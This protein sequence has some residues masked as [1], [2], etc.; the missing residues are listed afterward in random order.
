VPR[1][2]D[3]P[4][5]EGASDIA[6]NGGPQFQFTEAISLLVHCDDQKEVDE[7]WSKLSAGGQEQ[8]CGWLKDKIGLSW[9]II[10]TA[11]LR[12]LQDRDAEKS[13]RVMEAMLPMK[14]IEIARL[15]E[16]YGRE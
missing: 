1:R 16:A 15:E 6:L 2:F 3:R 13:K 5:P 9:Q 14:K 11:L 4:Q 7:L 8:P 12:M 10:P